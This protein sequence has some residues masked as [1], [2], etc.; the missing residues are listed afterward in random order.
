MREPG[1]LNSLYGCKS[2]VHKSLLAHAS[3]MGE[4]NFALTLFGSSLIERGWSPSMSRRMEWALAKERTRMW[5]LS[6]NLRMCKW[7]GGRPA[8]V[9]TAPFGAVRNEPVIHLAALACMDLSSPRGPL[10]R[11][12]S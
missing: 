11:H 10:L 3:V 8:M 12:P 1:I 6:T 2:P 7:M 4:R 9:S 5:L